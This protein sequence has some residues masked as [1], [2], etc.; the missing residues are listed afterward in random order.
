MFSVVHSHSLLCF[1][2]NCVNW[3]QTKQTSRRSPSAVLLTLLVSEDQLDVELLLQ[4][5]CNLH[6]YSSFVF[7]IKEV[8]SSTYEMSKIMIHVIYSKLVSR[9][10]LNG[11]PDRIDWVKIE[12]LKSFNKKLILTQDCN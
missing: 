6:S 8:L 4:S 7:W 1:L 10:D 2:N 11:C 12:I 5:S 9:Y 3:N